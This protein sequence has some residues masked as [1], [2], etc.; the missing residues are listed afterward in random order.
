MAEVKFCTDCRWVGAATPHTNL[1]LCLHPVSGVYRRMDVVSGEENAEP[2][3]CWLNR[4]LGACGGEARHWEPA[5]TPV[6]F[7]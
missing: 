4:G 1:R 6:G 5:D 7:V 3:A 2:M